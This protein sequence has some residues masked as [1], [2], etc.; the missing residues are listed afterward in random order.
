MHL[1]SKCA[2]VIQLNKAHSHVR[3]MVQD[4]EMCYQSF[5]EY[6]IRSCREHL[7]RDTANSQGHLYLHCTKV[8]LRRHRDPV[9]SLSEEQ[10][11]SRILL[12]PRYQGSKLEAHC[13]PNPF[14]KHT[15]TS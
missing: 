4:P 3:N 1:H 7:P 8:G 2:V 14:H 9:E 10:L 13:C 5:S 11:S 12:F 15:D 6:R